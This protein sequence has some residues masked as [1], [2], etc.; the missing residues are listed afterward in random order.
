MFTKRKKKKKSLMGLIE[1]LCGTFTLK[2]FP[3]Y[4]EGLG[5]L[6]KNRIDFL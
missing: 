6:G 1:P 4:V 2:G 3:N 5:S